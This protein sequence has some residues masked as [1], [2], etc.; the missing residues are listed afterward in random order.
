[1]T[2][3]PQIWPVIHV[4]DLQTS[5]DNAAI[6][7]ACGASGVFLISMHGADNELLPIKDALNKVLPGFKVGA[8]YLGE[9]SG[10]AIERSA[11]EGFDATWS[12]YHWG[13]VT[14]NRRPFFAPVAF[15][16]PTY[17]DPFPGRV[18]REAVERGF[19]PMTSGNGTGV[20]APITKI[21]ELR[22]SI[23]P[24]APL[25]MSGVDVRKLDVLSE[26]VTHF[27]IATCISKNFYEFDEKMLRDF[28]ARTGQSVG[29]K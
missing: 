18:A 25:A 5:I 15:K 9:E 24:G 13:Y 14:D 3:H 26:L 4:R 28:V 16:G 12:D 22:A 23:G 21:R 1:M 10:R 17:Y 11:T 7:Q 2:K 29:V 8:N 20:A 27:L 6:A 19:I